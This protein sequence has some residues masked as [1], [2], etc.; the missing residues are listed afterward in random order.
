MKVSKENVLLHKINM[1]AFLIAQ[2]LIFIIAD[3]NSIDFYFVLGIIIFAI[4]FFIQGICRIS[5][6]LSLNDISKIGL[7][8]KYTCTLAVSCIFIYQMYS[9]SNFVFMAISLSLSVME[10]L[11]IFVIAYR[12][13]ISRMIKRLIQVNRR[14]F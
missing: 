13:K 7:T 8:F 4:L 3:V 5:L 14:K 11:L 1:W 9:K 12:Y 2:I 6:D 10:I